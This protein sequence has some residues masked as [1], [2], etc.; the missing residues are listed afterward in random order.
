M[1]GP[2]GVA[3]WSTTP[4]TNATADG[5]A[6]NWAENQAPST[7]N[8]SARQNLADIR[9]MMNDAIWFSYGSGDQASGTTYLGTPYVYASSTSV[10]VAGVDVTTAH[11]AGRR[12]K[13]VGS[14]TGTIYGTISSSSFSTNTTINLTW[15]SGSLSNE[16]LTGYLSQVPVTGT[17]VPFASVGPITSALTIT[18]NSANALAVGRQGAT[19]P[20]LQVDASASSVATGLAIT[21]AAALGGVTLQAISSGGNE[22]FTIKAKG[23]GALTL[24][25]SGA[26]T[27]I[28]GSSASVTGS[29][30]VIMIG[31]ALTAASVVLRGSG[32]SIN[33]LTIDTSNSVQGS[34]LSI[35]PNTTAAP[36][37]LSVLSTGTNTPLIIDAKGSGTITFGSVSTGAIIHTTATTLSA[38]LTYGGVTF[39]NTATGSGS[40]V[41]SISPTLTGTLTAGAANFSG[42]VIATGA[43]G[44]LHQPTTATGVAYAQAANTGGSFYFA[45][46][47]SAGSGFG[48]GVAYGR[49]IFS[50]GSHPICI[51]INNVLAEEIDTSLNHYF[52]GAT[53]AG[54]SAANV[55]VIKNGT[56]PAS[57]PAGLGQLYVE[58]GALKYRGSS[59]TVTTLGVA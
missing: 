6:S 35:Q 40:L 4:A 36:L 52:G 27:A 12:M 1:A 37:A 45:I 19:N 22:A 57:S 49:A 9:A 50:D 3:S 2:S 20:V 8:N 16:T 42:A 15:D 33:A 34:G 54:T 24:G 59:G 23:N 53:S 38:A 46:D 51:F 58:S 5:G 17:P 7:V 26:N 30:S 29:T 11:H 43:T 55:L 14:G 41:G 39:A 21:G 25:Q 32:A 56:A 10:T 44:L 47:N 13:F 28:V 31:P 18:S 48:T